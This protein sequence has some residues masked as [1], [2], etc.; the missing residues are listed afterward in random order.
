MH[1]HYLLRHDLPC[2]LPLQQVRFKDI[3]AF[4]C[5]HGTDQIVRQLPVAK[6]DITQ[7][8]YNSL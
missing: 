4:I 2:L 7:Q 6:S 8:V 5:I 1:V 3:L